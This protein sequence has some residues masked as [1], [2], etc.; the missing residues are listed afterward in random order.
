LPIFF[1]HLHLD[2]TA[3]YVKLALPFVLWFQIKD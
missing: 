2:V 1:C 3:A